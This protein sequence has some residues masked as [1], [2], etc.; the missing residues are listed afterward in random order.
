MTRADSTWSSGD[1]AVIAQMH[2]QFGPQ[3]MVRHEK[4]QLVYQPEW[5]LHQHILIFNIEHFMHYVV[6][7]FSLY[8]LVV[9]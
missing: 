9:L 7:W 3:R 6:T 2:S 5:S 8:L 4:G 1:R